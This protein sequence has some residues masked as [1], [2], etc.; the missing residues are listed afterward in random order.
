MAPPAPAPVPVAAQP[1]P[2]AQPA[3]KPIIPAALPKII[4]QPQPAVT[5]Q[6]IAPVGAMPVAPEV[7]PAPPLAPAPVA[8]IAP[9]VALP[10]APPV[11]PP[12]VPPVAPPLAPPVA[13]PLAPP[14]APALPPQIAPQPAPPVA[15]AAPGATT[16]FFPDLGIEI[17]DL[18][19]N[20]GKLFSKIMAKEKVL[21]DEVNEAIYEVEEDYEYGVTHGDLVMMVTFI[22]CGCLL[23]GFI[24]VCC[25][26][27][28]APKQKLSYNDLETSPQ[29]RL[30]SL[31]GAQGRQ[32]PN[33]KKTMVKRAQ[34]MVR[35]MS[36]DS[37]RSAFS[38][39]R[40]EDYQ[41][42]RRGREKVNYKKG[43]VRQK[44]EYWE[45]DI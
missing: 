16:S 45:G 19:F 36:I 35:E 43:Q 20:F 4:A 44:T 26:K 40:P 2:V 14:V 8:P 24:F 7:V 34:K 23:A 9:Q 27:R 6:K 5:L 13:P 41:E 42:E 17:P 30:T 32:Q 15:P 12:I 28:I 10:V 18:G 31:G 11:A 39:P 22:L 38:D 37:V 29:P 25:R 3:V 21:E 1:K 33:N